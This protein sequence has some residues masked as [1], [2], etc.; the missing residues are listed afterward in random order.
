VLGLYYPGSNP[1]GWSTV[2]CASTAQRY[3]FVSR[4]S[5]EPLNVGDVLRFKSSPAAPDACRQYS[6]A[7]LF[8]NL[9]FLSSRLPLNGDVYDRVQ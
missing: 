2:P 9:G 5:R 3:R 4:A 7:A 1:V 8:G 6:F